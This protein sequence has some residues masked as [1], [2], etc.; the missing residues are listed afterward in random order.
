[1]TAYLNNISWTVSL[2]TDDPAYVRD[3]EVSY[4]GYSRTLM[5][6]GVATFP[7]V[8][9][10]RPFSSPIVRYALFEAR[11]GESFSVVLDP[12]TCT[13]GAIPT[14]TLTYTSNGEEQ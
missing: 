6:D 5:S 3:S 2:H 9:E 7:A 10:G 8:E 11:G 14:I 12:L 4:P 1:M 13:P